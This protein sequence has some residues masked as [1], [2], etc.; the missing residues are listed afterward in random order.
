[1][2]GRRRIAGVLL[3]VVNGGFAAWGFMAAAFPAYLLGPGGK[4]ILPAGYEGY[5]GGS[6]A[7]LVSSSP[8]TAQ[9]PGLD[10][11][12]AFKSA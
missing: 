1:M 3:L 6:W 9:R 8:M 11:P 7:E 5:G 2:K 10:T 12:R 4:P